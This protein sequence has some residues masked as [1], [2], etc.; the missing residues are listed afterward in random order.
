MYTSNKRL[1]KP[2]L[3]LPEMISTNTLFVDSDLG[4]AQEELEVTSAQDAVV[5]HVGR[6]VDRTRAVDRAVHFHVRM[7]D[8]Q[9]F[10]FIL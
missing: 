9:V 6:Q 8:V 10:L 2:Y 1:Y 4:F 3:S 5:L 7:N